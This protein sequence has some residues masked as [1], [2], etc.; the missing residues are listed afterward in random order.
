MATAESLT[1]GEVA[2]ELGRSEGSSD[3]FAGSV[4]A[5]SSRVKQEVLGVAPGPV[6]T[7]ECATEMAEGARRLLGVD[8]AVSM[9]GVGGPGEEEGKPAGTVFFAVAGP[10]GT[11]PAARRFDGEPDAV[12]RA[13]VVAALELLEAALREQRDAA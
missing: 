1:G 4:V 12:V 8:F 13:S 7:P 10:A 5:Y 9:T 2:T 3:W 6:V 11:A